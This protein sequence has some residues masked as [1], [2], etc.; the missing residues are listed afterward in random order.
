MTALWRNFHKLNLLAV[1]NIS[2][3][4]MASQS[5]TWGKRFSSDCRQSLWA[6]KKSLPGMQRDREVERAQGNFVLLYNDSLSITD[7]LS[8]TTMRNTAR[9]GLL[10]EM[11]TLFS[12]AQEEI[13][14]IA[15]C[16]VWSNRISLSTSGEWLRK[17]MS[18]LDRAVWA[19]TNIFQ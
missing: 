11:S 19:A 7:K 9:S 17:T 2:A 12:R 6:A 18:P 16:H 3:G 4:K 1:K 14:V 15:A 10:S 8:V 13:R 5:C